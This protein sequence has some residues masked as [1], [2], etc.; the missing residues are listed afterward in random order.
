MSIAVGCY[1]ICK[2][3][4]CVDEE[5]TEVLN[6]DDSVHVAIAAER[7]KNYQTIELPV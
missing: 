5:A 1:Q 7:Q 4:T 2:K 3:K 6:G